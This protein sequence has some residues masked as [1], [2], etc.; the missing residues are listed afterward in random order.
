[1]E[2]VSSQR[3]ELDSLNKDPKR[4]L[5]N[6]E[7]EAHFAQVEKSTLGERIETL[8]E[9][10]KGL[11]PEKEKLH[12]ILKEVTATCPDSKRKKRSDIYSTLN[13]KYIGGASKVLTY[14]P[15]CHACETCELCSFA[16][17]RL[18]LDTMSGHC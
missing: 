7:A 18:D 14:V 12:R 11:H 5:H 15:K 13:L 8:E 2:G 10:N 9:D 17:I 16:K 3:H 1:M 6:A 4:S